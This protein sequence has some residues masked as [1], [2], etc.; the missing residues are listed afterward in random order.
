M[1]IDVDGTSGGTIVALL[2]KLPSLRQLT[3]AARYRK[4]EEGA[5]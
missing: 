5:F 2:A 1:S 3:R 4:K